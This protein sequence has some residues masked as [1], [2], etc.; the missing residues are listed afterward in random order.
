[1]KEVVQEIR[2]VIDVDERVD[3]LDLWHP[4][5]EQIGKAFGGIVS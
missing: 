4:R 2:V 1:L 5:L 3:Q